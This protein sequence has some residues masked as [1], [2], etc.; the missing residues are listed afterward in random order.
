VS[1]SVQA[2]TAGLL[3][4]EEAAEVRENAALLSKPLNQKEMKI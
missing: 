2:R 3:P 4:W 1:S